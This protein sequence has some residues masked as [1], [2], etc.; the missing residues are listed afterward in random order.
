MLARDSKHRA[1]SAGLFAAAGEPASDVLLMSC[2]RDARVQQAA[3]QACVWN[4]ASD[5]MC[6]RHHRNR[7][8]LNEAAAP[9]GFRLQLAAMLRMY[10]ASPLTRGRRDVRVRPRW[11]CR[12]TCRAARHVCGTDVQCAQQDWA[13]TC[14]ATRAASCSAA[15]SGHTASA[16]S[17]SIG[18]IMRAPSHAIDHHR[19]KPSLGPILHRAT[20]RI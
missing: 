4:A 13:W 9:D 19:G 16:R 17:G 11:H 5:G 14:P 15:D 18:S 2:I 3:A 1:A 20:K 7:C 12:V 10:P 6:V 8:D